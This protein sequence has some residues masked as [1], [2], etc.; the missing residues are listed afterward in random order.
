MCVVCGRGCV[1]EC[2]RAC[3][4]ACVRVPIFSNDF[5]IGLGYDSGLCLR[6]SCVI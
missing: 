4:R 1:S 5:C 3:V 2:A 6:P